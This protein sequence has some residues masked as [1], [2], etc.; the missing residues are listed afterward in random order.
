MPHLALPQ[1]QMTKEK[2]AQWLT[3]NSIEQK[4]HEE[5]V[6]YTEEEIAQFEHQSSLASRAI[7]RLTAILDTFK[8]AINHGVGE[9][10]NYTI[11]ETKGMKTL[12]ENREF[13]DSNIERGYAIVPTQ[14]YGVPCTSNG[15]ICFFDILGEHW[16]QYDYKMNPFQEEKYGSP[17]F[18]QEEN[19]ID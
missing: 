4:T 2:L 5:N 17:L 8:D 14:L 13:A 11:P 10:T 19:L 1:K 16:E 3:E 15:K 18:K 7:D 9:P 6:D 12:K